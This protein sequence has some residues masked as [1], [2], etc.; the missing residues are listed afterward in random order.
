MPIQIDCWK[1]SDGVL[2]EHELDAIEHEQGIVISNYIYHHSEKVC[3]E[4]SKQQCKEL[5]MILLK[6]FDI[7]PK[8]TV[9]KPNFKHNL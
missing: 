8:P 5:A 4:M 6:N 2:F 9:K 1:T 7:T 3:A